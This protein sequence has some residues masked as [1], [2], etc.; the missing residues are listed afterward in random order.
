MS[1]AFSA[2]YPPHG[3]A[4]NEV[5][6]LFRGSIGDFVKFN[7]PPCDYGSPQPPAPSPKPYNRPCN[8]DLPWIN[9]ATPH[10]AM[11][12]WNDPFH[13]PLFERLRFPGGY[14]PVVKNNRLWTLDPVLADD[15]HS[16]EI[17]CRDAIIGMMNISGSWLLPRYF[18]LQMMPER[19]GYRFGFRTRQE[20]ENAV[21]KARNAFLPL[22]GALSLMSLIFQHLYIKDNLADDW[23]ERLAT[24]AGVHTAWVSRLEDSM[25]FDLKEPRVG[26]IVRVKDWIGMDAELLPLFRHVNMPIFLSWGRVDDEPSA[27]RYFVQKNCVPSKQDIQRLHRREA[28]ENFI[29]QA[30]QTPRRQAPQVSE[31][32]GHQ[33]APARSSTPELAPT[34]PPHPEPPLPFP[35]VERYSGQRSNEN[36]EEFFKRRAEWNIR[37]LQ[38]ETARERQSREAK[39][40]NAERQAC[41]GRAGARVYIWEEVDGYR[42]RRAAGRPNYDHFWEMYQPTQRRYDGFRDEWDLCSEFDPSAED[43]VSDDD[44]SSDDSDEPLP[45]YSPPP[46][47]C[48]INAVGDLMRDLANIRDD[49]PPLEPNPDIPVETLDDVAYNKFGFQEEFPPPSGTTGLAWERVR[50]LLGEGYGISRQGVLSHEMQQSMSTF[51]G[52]LATAKTVTD[53]PAALYDINQTASDINC[54]PHNTNISIIGEEPVY[55]V[56]VPCDVHASG[57]FVAVR[58][59]ATVIEVIRRIWDRDVMSIVQELL[60]RCIPFKLCIPGPYRSHSM[61][62]SFPSVSSLGRRMRNSQFD[63]VDFLLYERLRDEFLRSPRGHLALLAGGVIA[64]LA[65]EVIP[66]NKVYDGPADNVEKDGMFIGKVKGGSGYYSDVLS[67]AEVNLVLGVYH[68]DTSE[69]ISI[70]EFHPLL[71]IF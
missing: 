2:L 55:Y 56:F 30:A 68:V 24:E 29:R 5:F 19:F 52:Y 20:A 4:G 37:A 23:R 7:V 51:F 35:P 17:C 53:I 40:R 59:P 65:C 45:A 11:I 41:P 14:V 66:F 12:P 64:R 21:E 39:E 44:D 62:T 1:S 69:L 38:R 28:Q 61:P 57:F 63:E 13:G 48:E 25:L 32:P 22:M 6:T 43:Q 67:E 8:G 58:S 27:P 34:A 50:K 18:Q 10:M 36:I 3:L 70:N 54:L 42:I 33:S 26:G 16:L 47:A 46:P 71:I 9:P 31:V 60:K 49:G 15:W